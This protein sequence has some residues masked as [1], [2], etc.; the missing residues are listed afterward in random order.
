M[1]VGV[2]VSKLGYKR[3]AVFG[4]S[5]ATGREVVRHVLRAGLEVVSVDQTLPD[6]AARVEGVSYRKADV[7][8][9][10]MTQAMEGC[11]AVISTL[12]VAFSPS[13]ALSPP[14]LYIEGTGNILGGMERAGI[15]RIAVIS[16]A[17]V[18]DQ[19]NLPNWFKLTVV[20]ALHNIL[21]QMREMETLLEGRPDLRWTIVRPAWLLHKPAAGDLLV[22]EEFLP[23]RAFRCRIG[24]L[25]A[26]LVECVQHDRHVH[27][28][29]AVGAPEEE[30]FESP[31]A[32]G[33]EFGGR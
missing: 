23:D 33:D 10:D 18:I 13:N 15:K 32:L 4:G 1:D 25:A 5:G 6:E 11:D 12:G 14:P 24:D 3:I 21:E 19:P 8:K 28:K 31:L 2:G 17:F 27:A 16:A 26:F 9:G 29:P 22:E 20:P 30:E 7:L